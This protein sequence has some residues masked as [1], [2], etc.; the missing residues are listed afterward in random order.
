MI[1]GIKIFNIYSK[2]DYRLKFYVSVYN[3]FVLRK[4]EKILKKIK[5]DVVHAD[6]VQFHLSYAILKKA[7]K[8]AKGV[9][10]TARDHTL[11]SSGKFLQKERECGEINY[12][13]SWLDDFKKAGV[14][15]NP[16]R[17]FFIKRYLKYVDKIFAVSTEL[18]KALNQ[19]GILNTSVIH[20]GLP[21][22]GVLTPNFTQS[23]TKK[24]FLLGRVNESKG[25]Y[26]LLDSFSIVLRE[27]PSAEIIIAGVKNDEKEKILK[28]AER[29]GVRK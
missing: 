2:Y 4:A 6:I 17:A 19:N 24:I 7:K 13:V 25:V 9:F 15:F 21:M 23:K 3:P 1:D 11:F 28:Y 29:A 16:L 10:F 27:V 8:Y 18:E 26:A 22:F 20:N 12:R 14:R 5:P